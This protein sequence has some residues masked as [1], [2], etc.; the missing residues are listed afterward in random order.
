METSTSAFQPEPREW[1]HR[2]LTAGAKMWCGAT[3]FFFASFVF[4]Y[5]YLKSLDENHGWKVLHVGS[6]HVSPSGGLGVSIMAVY[7]LSGILLYLGSRR[8][9]DDI[10]TG[11]AAVVLALAGVALQ[12]AEYSH[13]GFGP[14]SGGYASVFFGWTA[15]YAL[16][17]LWGVYWMETTVAGLWRARREGGSQETV[18]LL[19]TGLSACSICWSFFVAIGVLMFVV[20]YLL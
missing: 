1:A 8:P 18:A 10:S 12:F 14:T 17:A 4:A 3:A 7:L 6:K 2:S 16:G 9:A 19:R 13:L 20:L 15:T 11:V 5:F